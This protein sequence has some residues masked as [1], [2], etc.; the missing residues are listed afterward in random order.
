MGCEF[1]ITKKARFYPYKLLYFVTKLT[2]RGA[3]KDFRLIKM[4]FDIENWLWKLEFQEWQEPGSKSQFT[5]DCNFLE[6][7]LLY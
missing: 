5:K 7:Q 2:Y 1:E 4:I 6:A 3:Y